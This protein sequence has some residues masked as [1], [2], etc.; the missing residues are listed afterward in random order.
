MLATL[1]CAGIGAALR[2]GRGPIAR[3]GRTAPL[4][5]LRCSATIAAIR[6]RALEG[7]GVAILPMYFVET[8]SH[9]PGSCGYLRGRAWPRI[10]FRLSWRVG[11]VHAPELQA[12]A[13]ELAARPLR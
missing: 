3:R 1:D 6:A 8:T 11:H 7:A 13:V 2:P 12:L 10:A 4:L 9:E 5:R